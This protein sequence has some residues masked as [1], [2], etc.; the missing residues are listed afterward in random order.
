MEPYTDGLIKHLELRFQQVG[1]LA[2]FSV[3]GPKRQDDAADLEHLMML[4]KQFSSIN[5]SQL[6]QEW[7][8]FKV[9][10]TSGILKVSLYLKI[11]LNNFKH[12][13]DSWC[14]SLFSN[15]IRKS[16]NWRS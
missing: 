1:I 7:Q 6:L 10:I 3:L 8:S 13:K 12:F 9:L 11:T 14:N 16:P 15:S 5:E 4:A 2:A